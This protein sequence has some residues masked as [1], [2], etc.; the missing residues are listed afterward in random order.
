M[1]WVSLFWVNIIIVL[2]I[3]SNIS[4][5]KQYTQRAGYLNLAHN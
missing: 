3:I 5:N 1:I 2:C 4:F